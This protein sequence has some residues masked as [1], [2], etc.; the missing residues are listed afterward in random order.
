MWSETAVTDRRIG[1]VCGRIWDEDL[2]D[3][4]SLLGELGVEIPLACRWLSI[5][6]STV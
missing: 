6:D 5:T 3:H 1:A 4:G 2:V